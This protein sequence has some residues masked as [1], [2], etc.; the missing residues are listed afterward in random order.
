MIKEKHKWIL[1]E[2]KH[3]K[4]KGL[5]QRPRK[6]TRKGYANFPIKWSVEGNF[7]EYGFKE[8]EVYPRAYMTYGIEGMGGIVFIDMESREKAKNKQLKSAIEN[9]RYVKHRKELTDMYARQLLEFC[10]KNLSEEN[11][12]ESD[13]EKLWQLYNEF[14]EI[15]TKYEFYNSIWFIISDDLQ[16]IVLDKLGDMGCRDFDEIQTLVTCP[17][18]S[19]ANKEKI[20]LLR[21][22][23]EIDKNEKLKSFVKAAKWDEFRASSCFNLLVE[24]KEKYYWIPFG[25]IGPELYDEK[26]YFER[27]RDIFIFSSEIQTELNGAEEFYPSVR[28]K[29]E[30]ILTKYDV[31]VETRRLFNDLHVLALMQDERKELIART[32]IP[33]VRNLMGKIGSFFGLSGEEAAELYPSVIENCLLTGKVDLDL[34]KQEREQEGVKNVKLTEPDGYTVYLEDDAQKFLDIILSE[35]VVSELSGMC[36]CSGKVVGRVKVLRDA[37]DWHKME[38]GDILV[39]TMT[40]PDFLP[41]MEKATAIVTDEGGV[42]CHAAIVSREFNIPCVVGTDVATETLKDGDMVEVNADEGKVRRI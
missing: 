42:T 22:A 7:R 26:R 5:I 39:T 31:D 13:K 19:F 17:Y 14:R 37:N 11:V 28:K 25:H 41:Y 32:H 23:L 15:Y 20:D 36:A 9:P 10:E 33:W 29:Q 2:L 34:Y 30:G 16:R 6:R 24:L 18:Q 21:A 4:Q 27:L 1:E 12:R 3:L 40:T 8:T 38:K 35:S